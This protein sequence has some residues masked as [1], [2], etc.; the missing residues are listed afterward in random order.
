MEHGEAPDASP[1]VR[2]RRSIPVYV[3]SGGIATGSHYVVT[4]A[5]VEMFG[6]KAIVASMLGYATG[7]MIKYW[8]NYSVAFRSSARHSLALA[9]FTLSQLALL[10]L[11][12]ALFGLL[13]DGLHAHYLVAQAITTV[14]LI[15]P[16]YVV[17]RAWVFR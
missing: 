16:G 17:H 14:L 5:A 15:A 3:G 6:I 9:R 13:Q 4:I 8:L 12:T 7:A 10:A 1:A 2:H 11:N